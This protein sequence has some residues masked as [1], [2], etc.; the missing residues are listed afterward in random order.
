MT[1]RTGGTRSPLEPGQESSQPTHSWEFC[2]PFLVESTIRLTSSCSACSTEKYQVRVRSPDEAVVPAVGQHP[3]RATHVPHAGTFTPHAL[4][5]PADPPVPPR[6]PA[7]PH[8]TSSTTS[9]RRTTRRPQRRDP[10]RAGT[11]H[12]P[13]LPRHPIPPA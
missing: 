3:L 1:S 13:Q 2:A 8:G 6:A 7:V 11:A 10:P 9:N 4:R 5:V 12:H